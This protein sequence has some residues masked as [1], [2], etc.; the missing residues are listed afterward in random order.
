M[1]SCRK[2]CGVPSWSDF[3]AL[4]LRRSAK[5]FKVAGFTIVIAACFET[6]CR[7]AKRLRLLIFHYKGEAVPVVWDG[8]RVEMGGTG[9]PVQGRVI[10]PEGLKGRLALDHQSSG[11]ITG[12]YP[13][14]YLVPMLGVGK[15]MPTRGVGRVTAPGLTAE[16]RLCDPAG[17]NFGLQ[18]RRLA[19]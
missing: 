12:R 1:A 10:I 14:S 18:I 4:S 17:F 11:R 2:S 7:H 19:G 15:P 3:L 16:Y 6:H 9:R 13:I 8:V 5:V